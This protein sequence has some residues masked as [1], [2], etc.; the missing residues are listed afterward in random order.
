MVLFLLCI[1]TFNLRTVQ[2]LSQGTRGTIALGLLVF[3]LLYLIGFLLFSPFRFEES[4]LQIPIT[5]GHFEIS[6]FLETESSLIPLGE[7]LIS[8]YFYWV[9]LCCFGI[10]LVALL[11]VVIF[12][13]KDSEG[14]V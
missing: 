6:A 4:F 12:F 7:L 1:F 11:F 14:K 8:S 10:L 3:F 2:R 5:P 9:V 13:T